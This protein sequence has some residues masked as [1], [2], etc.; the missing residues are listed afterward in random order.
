MF[1]V[2]SEAL[3]VNAAKCGEYREAGV[4]AVDYVRQDIRGREPDHILHA[5]FEWII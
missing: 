4:L 5:T 3:H 1:S 2:F